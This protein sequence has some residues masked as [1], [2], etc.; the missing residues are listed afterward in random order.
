[1][2]LSKQDLF[3]DGQA[4]TGTAATDSENVLDWGTGGVSGLTA[5]TGLASTAFDKKAIGAGAHGDD[6]RGGLYLNVHVTG[7][8]ADDKTLKVE[9][10]TSD[11]NASGATWTVVR[12]YGAA[13]RNTWVGKNFRIANERLPPGLKRYQKLSFTSAV[14]NAATVT[15]FITDGRVDPTAAFTHL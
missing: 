14:A 12:D 10:K 7:S 1:M 13:A 6:L 15:A 8:L 2:V 4:L 9:W 5:V 3:C 11:S